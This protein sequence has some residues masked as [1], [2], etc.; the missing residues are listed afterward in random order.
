MK[1]LSILSVSQIGI[2]DIFSSEYLVFP[3]PTTSD[4]TGWE[5]TACFTQDLSLPTREF[6]RIFSGWSPCKEWM[7]FLSLRKYTETYIYIKV[8]FLVVFRVFFVVIYMVVFMAIFVV[9]ITVFICQYVGIRFL[10]RIVHSLPFKNLIQPIP[11]CPQSA[12]FFFCS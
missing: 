6:F 7:R 11:P 12:Q 4:C 10:S 5:F 3:A 2:F 1:L 9:V 8:V